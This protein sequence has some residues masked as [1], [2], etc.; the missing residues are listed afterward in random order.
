METWCFS[1]LTVAA[2]EHKEGTAAA[3]RGVD[4]WCFVL[5]TMLNSKAS[6]ISPLEASGG[7]TFEV[8]VWPVSSCALLE[9]KDLALVSRLAET[10]TVGV[11]I[12]DTGLV[13]ETA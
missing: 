11:L 7:A 6:G 2:A 8:A 12:V 5:M 1:G 9:G 3:V 13:K 10:P 4:P